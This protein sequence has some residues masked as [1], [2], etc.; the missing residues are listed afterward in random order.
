M[1]ESSQIVLNKEHSL[2]EKKI[3]IGYT[4]YIQCSSDVREYSQNNFPLKLE[5]SVF[6]SHDEHL[7]VT[8][9]PVIN[10]WFTLTPHLFTRY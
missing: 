10:Y 6:N 5:L 2:G 8:M 1:N 7:H 4:T 9:C 3:Y